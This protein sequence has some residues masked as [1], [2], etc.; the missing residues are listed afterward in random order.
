LM[1]LITQYPFILKE[2]LRNKKAEMLAPADVHQ[3]N[4]IAAEMYRHIHHIYKRGLISGEQLIIL[5][6]HCREFTNIAGSCERIKRTPI[7][8]S[9]SLFIKKVIFVYVMTMPFSFVTEYRYATIPIVVFVFYVLA[10]LE[11]IA[12][13][14]E[15]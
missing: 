1:D 11:L 3:P 4:Y 7:P 8:F 9:Y 12:E 14:I 5:D 2:H 15:D 10:S 6:E 13:E